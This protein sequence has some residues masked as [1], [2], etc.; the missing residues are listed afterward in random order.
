MRP[1]RS[2]LGGVTALL[3]VGALAVLG[4]PIGAGAGLALLAAWYVFGPLPAFAIG[5]VAVVAL[6]GDWSVASIAAAQLAVFAM[7]VAPD[8]AS[9]HGRRLAAAT[10]AGA[11]LLGAVTYG[12]QSGWETTWTS[13]V[14]LGGLVALAAYGLHRYELLATGGLIREQ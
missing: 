12:A 7:L 11:T 1:D 3:A 9:P 8:L 14:V 2:R 5:Q 4:G 6:A 10:A 13:A